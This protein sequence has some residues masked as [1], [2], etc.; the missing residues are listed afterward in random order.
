MEILNNNLYDPGTLTIGFD[1]NDRRFVRQLYFSREML[2]TVPFVLDNLS[3]IMLNL[4]KKHNLNDDN[5]DLLFF[6]L[7]QESKFKCRRKLMEFKNVKLENLQDKFKIWCDWLL[8]YISGE[9]K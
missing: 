2:N 8:N 5:V 1:Y 9:D 7:F 4:P 3:E 6:F